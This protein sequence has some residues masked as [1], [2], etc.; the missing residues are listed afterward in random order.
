MVPV[1]VGAATAITVLGL[2]AAPAF[3][4]SDSALSG[5]HNAQ[6][7]HAYHLTVT[8]G[9][10]AG[11][12]PARARL[13]IRDARGHFHWYGGWQRLHRTN[14]LDETATFSVTS[15]HRGPKTFRA[16]ITG[17]ATTNAVTVTIL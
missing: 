5:P 8:V 17:Y 4:K 10:D 12:R 2:A 9:D 6:M 11:A 13:Q 3:A 1:A 14:Y 15:Q 16:V 7:R